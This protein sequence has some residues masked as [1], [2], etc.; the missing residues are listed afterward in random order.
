MDDANQR[1]YHNKRNGGNYRSY[2]G[3]TVDRNGTV[4]HNMGTIGRNEDSNY[5]VENFSTDG[6]NNSGWSFGTITIDE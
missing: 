2:Q 4:H 5:D 6:E 3:E 1:N